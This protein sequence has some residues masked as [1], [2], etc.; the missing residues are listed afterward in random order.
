[1][2]VLVLNVGSSS[3]KYTIYNKGKIILKGLIEKIKDK[4]GYK[5]GLNE[6]ADM[7]EEKAIRCDAIGHRVVHGDDISES[8]IIDEKVLNIIEKM[9]ELAPL[10]NVPELLVIR[11]C[12]RIFPGIK[13][14]AV[15]DTAFHTTMPTKAKLYALP[16]EYYEKNIKRYGFH[17]TS[18]K[19]VSL[20]LKGKVITCHLGNGCSISAVKNG[21]CLDTSM[22]LT[23]MEGLVMGTRCGDIDAGAIFYLL[24][25]SSLE[26]VNTLLNKKSGLLG[27]SGISNDVRDLIKSKSE[28]AKLAIDVFI[29]RVVKY[30]GAYAAALNGVDTLVFTAGIGE[31]AWYL[32]EEICDNLT[33]L[34]I[35]L[36][37]K[38]NRKNETVISASNSR[39][40]VMVIKTD[41]DKLIYEETIKVLS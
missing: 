33:Y 30:V 37:K 14:V 28:R 8:Q 41:E 19:Y 32:R 21:V 4:Q 22:G 15:F 20:G 34:G 11:E 9:G 7:M 27:I 38:K 10:H 1:M 39:V 40:K 18:H 17:G 13:Q 35:R 16:Y 36:D 26:D 2:N 3:I 31:N 23:P 25:R 5:A 24:K 12:E 6:I 29:Y